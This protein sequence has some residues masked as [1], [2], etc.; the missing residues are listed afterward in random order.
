[1]G[2]PFGKEKGC[3]QQIRTSGPEPWVANAIVP[4][5]SAKGTS[6]TTLEKRSEAGHIAA[7]DL[8][9]QSSGSHVFR[10]LLVVQAAGRLMLRGV[11]A[12]AFDNSFNCPYVRGAVTQHLYLVHLN[13]ERKMH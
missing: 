1:V 4:D 10:C 9:D 11:T 2:F 5:R 8:H 7:S 13:D 3:R 6:Q 12:A